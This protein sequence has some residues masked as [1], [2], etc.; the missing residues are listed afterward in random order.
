M[1]L[2]PRQNRPDAMQHCCDSY[3]I[4]TAHSTQ[5]TAVSHPKEWNSARHSRF[6]IHTITRLTTIWL[7][8]ASKYLTSWICM[9]TDY[10]LKMLPS[11]SPP[12]KCPKVR[13]PVSLIHI[14]LRHYKSLRCKYYLLII[15]NIHNADHEPRLVQVASLL[16]T[17]KS[18]KK[19]RLN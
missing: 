18:G 9:Y 11:P 19:W 4:H 2:W 8:F 5:H 7:I 12:C 15:Q 16:T 3:N 14:L 13:N 1:P 10:G 17:V 6:D